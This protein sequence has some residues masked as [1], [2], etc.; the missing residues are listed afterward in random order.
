MVFQKIFQKVADYDKWVAG[1]KEHSSA[2][3]DF[4]CVGTSVYT[5]PGNKQNITIVL[6]W[7]DKSKMQEFGSSDALKNAM[8]NAGVV[9]PPEMN[10]SDS[11][12]FDVSS[13]A[14]QFK[15]DS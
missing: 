10:F 3:K 9:G 7:T 6:E 5:E 14:F 8:Q 4:T 2:R 11:N 1:Y 15:T 13:L 12:T